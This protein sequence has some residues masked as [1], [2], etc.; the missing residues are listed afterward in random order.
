MDYGDVRGRQRNW[1]EYE[2]VLEVVSCN[3]KKLRAGISDLKSRALAC[4]CQ[5]K[6]VRSRGEN[7]GARHKNLQ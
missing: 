7:L 3:W 5:E 2:K 1:F 4:Y 6:E